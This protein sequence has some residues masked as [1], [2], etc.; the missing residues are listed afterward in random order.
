MLQIGAGFF[1][2]GKPELRIVMC[3]IR[4]QCCLRAKR[5]CLLNLVRT[6][7]GKARLLCNE[8]KGVQMADGFPRSG[9]S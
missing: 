4:S 1:G 3:P 7:L 2:P 9:C 8:R 6:L 5:L